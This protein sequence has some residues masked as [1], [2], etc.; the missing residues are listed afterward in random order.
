[1]VLSEEELGPDKEFMES[2][3][4]VEQRWRRLARATSH[5]DGPLPNTL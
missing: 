4:R 1:M 5:G 2:Y 3:C